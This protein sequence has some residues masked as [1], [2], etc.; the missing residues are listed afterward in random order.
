[1]YVLV[2]N[3]GSSSVKFAVITPEDG[4][5]VVVG[6]G[7]RLGSPQASLVWRQGEAKDEVVMPG[8]D[9]AAI[10][11]AVVERLRGAGMLAKLAG[12]GHR[13]VH[14]GSKFA[15]SVLVDTDV[16]AR[17][18][19]CNHLG[20]LH[21]PANLLGV[22]LGRELIPGVPQVAVFDTA[23]HQ[24]MPAKAFRYAIP[25]AWYQDHDARRYGFHGTSH[26]FVAQ[27]ATRLLSRRSEDCQLITAHLGNG[28]SAAA[29]LNG[30]SVDTT[31]GLTP[32]EGLV[33]G[34]RSGDVDPALVGYMANRLQCSADKVIDQ[35]NKNSGLQGL[36]GVSN[37]M[38]TL[39]AAEERGDT[40]ATLAVDVFCYR[41][42]KS[43]AGLS[44]A[45]TRIDAL[46]FTGGIG[47]NSRPVRQRTLGHL[48]ALGFAC[49][50][51][52]NQVDGRDTHQRISASGSRT[53]LVV[54]TNEELLIAR[55]TAALVAGR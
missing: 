18:S 28:C 45:L 25:E 14:G 13:V 19:S 6:L 46:V 37:D 50:P 33:M 52:A 23:F 54:P 17:I 11:S 51:V 21:N 31:M 24:T 8:A 1:M 10:I 22:R 49:D 36:S 40:R 27:E 2:L 35:L 4:A 12:I 29:V 53:V 7:Q 3:C 30:H 43:I 5:N 15:A 39:L 16:E 48:A 9:H 42:A 47:E 44:A 41:L 20:P 34:T 38:R 32:L 26:R 55:D